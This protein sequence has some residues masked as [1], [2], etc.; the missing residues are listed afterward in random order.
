MALSRDSKRIIGYLASSNE[1]NM[2]IKK[3]GFKKLMAPAS[4][5]NL[6][7]IN[8]NACTMEVFSMRQ[9]LLRRMRLYFSSTSSSV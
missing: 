2:N 5:F 9:L 7:V 6:A 8:D 3:N 1:V 4:N